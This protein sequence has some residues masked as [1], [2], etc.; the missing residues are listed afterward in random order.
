[1]S[2]K[3]VIQYFIKELFDNNCKRREKMLFGIMMQHEKC[4]LDR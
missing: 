3:I 4:K 2:S 1:M